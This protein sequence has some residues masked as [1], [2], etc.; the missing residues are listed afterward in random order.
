MPTL[1]VHARDDPFMTPAAIPGANELSSSTHLE[2]TAR[3]GHN[4]FVA[5][6]FPGRPYYWLDRRIPE[7][8]APYLIAGDCPLH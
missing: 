2:L 1:I 4:G 3:G 7:F 6:A 5:G 8:L